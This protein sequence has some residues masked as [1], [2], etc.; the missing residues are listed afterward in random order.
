L[1]NTQAFLVM[2][3]D[4]G[5]GVM[6]LENDRLELSW[7]GVGKE[8]IFQ[9]VD[10]N[11]RAATAAI[12]GEYVVNPSW[13][14]IMNYDLMTVHPL[15]GCVMGDDA[16]KGVVNHKGQVFSSTAGTDVYKGLYV[17]D[18]SVVPLPL[19]VNPLITISALAE[20]CCELMA[21]DY[22]LTIDYDF[23]EFTVTGAALTPGIQFTETM[24]GYFSADEKTDFAKGADLGKQS[25]CVFEFTLTVTS[26]DVMTMLHTNEHRAA[27]EGI[28]KAPALSSK[29]MTVSDGI[30]N[31][32]VNAEAD[33]P[34]KLM[35]YTMNIHSEEGKDYFFYGYKLVDDTKGFDL[36]KDTST[37]YITIHEGHDES[38]PVL[39]KG[40]LI[41]EM[42]DFTKQMTTMKVLNASSKFQELKIMTA[43]GKYFSGS[44]YDIYIKP[45]L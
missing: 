19:G 38:S 36:W 6:K 12:G 32:F 8:A 23:K 41:I 17:C 10:G 4:D 40:I 3:H 39:G 9:K 11:L 37:L 16:G 2:T 27:L 45:H 15:G 7:P 35:K 20:R 13:T 26:D 30:F 28:V 29:P 5:K 44:L 24:K 43:F 34:T 14:K 1:N 33:V 31:L 22:G 21:K 25:D 42:A 18:G